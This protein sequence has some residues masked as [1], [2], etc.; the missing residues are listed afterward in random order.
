VSPLGQTEYVHAPPQRIVSVVLSDDEILLELVAPERLA[1]VTYL[2]DDPSTTPSRAPASAARVTDE[3]PEGLLRLRPDL[4]VSA[5]YTRAEA[6]VLLQ[7]A[8]VPVL[9]TGAHANL[10]DVL[11]AIGTL[12]DVVDEPERARALRDSLR[13]RIDA[14][15]GRSR[16]TPVPRVL[17]WEGGFTYGRGTM[18]DDLVRRAGAV[19]VASEAAMTGPVA[20]TEEAAVSLAPDVILV[21]IEGPTPVWREPALLGDAPIWR[22]VDAVTRGDV[23]GIPRAWLGSVSH[24]AVRALEAVA[25]ILDARKP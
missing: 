16:R 17:V 11:S 18:P 4:V 3:D 21:P 8:G 6:I 9:G 13:A 12:G 20:L 14:V 15:E 24:H 2:I 1:G 25:D 23:Y 10:D 22:A 5:G 19:D 7:A